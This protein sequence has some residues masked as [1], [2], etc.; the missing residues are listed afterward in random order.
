MR[1][2]LVG[3]GVIARTHVA[4]AGKLGALDELRVVDPNREALAGFLDAFPEA[5]GFAG[6]EEMLA[7]EPGRDDDVVIVATPPRFHREPAIAAARSGRHVLCEKP[8][9]MTVGE[10]EEMLRAAGVD[11]AARAESIDL[12]GYLAIAKRL[13]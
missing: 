5:V 1:L 10:A 12:D 13:G 11:P 7:A 2:Y 4:A 3:A 8:L 6:A 9:A